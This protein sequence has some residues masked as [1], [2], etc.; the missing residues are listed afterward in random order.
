MKAWINAFV[1]V[2]VALGLS[3]KQA[4]ENAV[5]TLI[6]IQGALLVTKG[7]DDIGIFENSLKIIEQR[8]LKE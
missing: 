5:Q 8:Y 3:P 1:E 6:E 4:Y 2:G 7:M